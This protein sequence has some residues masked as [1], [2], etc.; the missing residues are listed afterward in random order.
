[1]IRRYLGAVAVVAAGSALAVFIAASGPDM[2]LQSRTRQVPA[3][4]TMQVSMQTVRM[5]VTTHGVVRP[6]TESDLTPEVE[7]R[8]VYLAPMMVSGGFFAKGDILVKI[9]RV[10]YELAYEQSQA[11]LATVRSELEIAEKSYQRRQ[12]LVVRE[13][14]SQ[15][16]YD[17]AQNRVTV[18]RASLREAVARVALAERD[19]ERTRL[20]APYDGRVRTERIAEGQFVRRGES[21]ATLYSVDFAEVRLPIDD[22]DLAFLPLSLA[23]A[24]GERRA[25]LKVILRAKFA[26][27][28]HSWEGRVVRTE[29]EMDS[30][31]RMFNVVAEVEAPY[32]QAGDRPPLTAGLFVEAEIFGHEFENVVVVPRSALQ[33]E[34]QLYIVSADQRL[35]F[36]DA[37]ILRVTSDSAFIG[38]GVEDGETVC[39]SALHGNVL[40][41]QLVRPQTA[42]VVSA[43]L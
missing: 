24:V 14:I 33:A 35:V 28:E 9:D 22:E 25:M 40:E 15:S 34:N 37:D 39:L 5:T 7:G 8:V 30:K 38:G 36:R 19:L 21:I 4:R 31:T 13:S 11:H 10:S 41:G 43:T 27:A 3:V 42:S 23:E 29:G 32:Q 2:Q 20:T 26:G 18:A 6:K 1:M 17:D 12:E 16:Q